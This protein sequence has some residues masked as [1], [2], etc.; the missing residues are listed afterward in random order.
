VAEHGDTDIF[1]FP[2]ENRVIFDCTEEVVKYLLEV[3]SDFDRF[4]TTYPP[5]NYGT[6]APVGYT[7]FRWATQIDPLW[8]VYFLA[9]VIRLGERIES[10]RLPATSRRVFSYR[11]IPDAAS[12]D[13]YDRNF[14]W[15]AFTKHG[16]IRIPV[17]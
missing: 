1:P 11:F 6:L 10:A 4:I 16:T 5:A 17:G 12:S 3:D 2:V 13:L 8:N 14:N 15:T 9:L 7:G